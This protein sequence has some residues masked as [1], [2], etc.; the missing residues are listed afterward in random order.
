MSTCFFVIIKT[1]QGD[2]L[3]RGSEMVSPTRKELLEKVKEAEE[4][5]R[6]QGNMARARNTA[7]TRLADMEPEKYHQLYKEE[8]AKRGVA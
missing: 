8:K 6:R 5:K 3:Q 7:L 4:K 2:K 1:G